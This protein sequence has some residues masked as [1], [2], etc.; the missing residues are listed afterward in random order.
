MSSEQ[1]VS[2]E[3]VPSGPEL[4]VE[5]CDGYFC[6]GTKNWLGT[7][8]L[9]LGVSGLDGP[10]E[11]ACPQGDGMPNLGATVGHGVLN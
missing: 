9:A 8:H 6:L 7:T 2:L 3:G 4:E 1:P 11:V 10:K 5:V